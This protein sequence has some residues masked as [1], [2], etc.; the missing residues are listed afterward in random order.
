MNWMLEKC[1][2]LAVLVSLRTTRPFDVSAMKTSTDS[3]ERVEMKASQ[4]PSGLSA[5][6]T[7][8]SALNAFPRTSASRPS[9]SRPTAISTG[10]DTLRIA[11]CQSFDS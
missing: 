9:S 4:R 1:G 8:S 10:A 6:P 2:S 3:R 11:A 5:G 7:F